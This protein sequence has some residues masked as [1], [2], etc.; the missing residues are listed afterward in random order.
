M[1]QRSEDHT[2]VKR[3][4]DAGVLRPEDVTSFLHKNVIYKS[5][6]GADKLELDAIQSFEMESGD[7]KMGTDDKRTLYPQIHSRPEFFC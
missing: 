3:F 5:L 1:V 6:G 4:L 7:I 2:M